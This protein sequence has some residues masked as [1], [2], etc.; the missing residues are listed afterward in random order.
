[1]I[2]KDII[3]VGGGIA[4]LTAALSLAHKGRDVLLIEKNESG[5]GRKDYPGYPYHHRKHEGSLWR[6]QSLV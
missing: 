3:V 6:R 2:Q 1:M 4:G 5:R